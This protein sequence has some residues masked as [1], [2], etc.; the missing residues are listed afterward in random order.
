MVNPAPAPAPA[1]PLAT[2]AHGPTDRAGPTLIRSVDLCRGVFAFLVVAAH[3][4]DVCWVIHPEAM[5]R[6]PQVI[7]TLLF[8]TVQS[9]FYWVMGF[10]VLSGY[11][12]QLSA[13]RMIDSGRFSIGLYLKAR[14]TRIMPLYYLALLFA[15][16]VESL[17]A[18]IRP[19]YYPDGLDGFGFG[20]QL[21]LI[22][23][24]TRTFGAFA[25]SWTI[26]NELFYYVGFG[27]L[28]VVAGRSRAR[29]AW[30]G[31]GCCVGLGGGL[32]GLHWLGYRHGLILGFGLLFGLGVNWFLGALVAIHGPRLVRRGAI[33]NLARLW[34]V[35]FAVAVGMRAGDR[36]PELAIDLW[37]GVTFAGLLLRLIAADQA[38][39][40]QRRPSTRPAW[41]GSLAE[42]VGLASY[43]TYLFHGPILLAWAALIGQTGMIGDWRVT[44]L[45]LVGSGIGVGCAL[46]WWLER[47]IMTWRAE[48]LARWK[49]ADEV[50]A[51]RSETD[52]PM[53]GQAALSQGV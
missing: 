46:G 23:R 51:R 29:P 1:P 7:R 18:P 10:F 8:A 39:Q 4:Y 34:P 17:V 49:R 16:G 28:A 50:A 31:L 30:V 11:C 12:I 47:P 41:L 15:L 33:R 37:L 6:L 52:R 20:A 21:I 35:G 36:I 38:D 32:I 42:F 25:P 26:T 9:G 45:L 44:W 5:S 3:S 22:Q 27:L 24:L 14:L 13:T 48:L 53:V 40:S 19:A 2:A 43:P